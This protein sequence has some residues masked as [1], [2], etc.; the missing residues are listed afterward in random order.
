MNWWWR[1]EPPCF[2]ECGLLYLLLLLKQRGRTIAGSVS[3]FSVPNM[4]KVIKYVINF[5][6]SQ[7]ILSV[8]SCCALRF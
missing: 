2:F 8:L 6:F 3:T 4:H 7:L 5:N 1:K